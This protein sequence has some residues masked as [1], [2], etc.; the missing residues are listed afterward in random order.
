MRTTPENITELADNEIF[1]FGSNLLGIHG[2]G[3]AKTARELFGAKLGV[4]E[5]LTGNC[6]A[7]PTVTRPATRSSLNSALTTYQLTRE[8]LQQVRDRLYTVARDLP[9]MTFLLTKVGC[10]LAGYPEEYMSSLFTDSP[11]NII[12]P[13]GW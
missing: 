8:H 9:K 6:Y 10:G 1:V 5:G 13:L 12:K 4:E 3:A 2:S 7:F 11:A